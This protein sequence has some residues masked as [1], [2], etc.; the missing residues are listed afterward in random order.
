MSS[1]YAQW[2]YDDLRS[3]Q[4]DDGDDEDDDIDHDIDPANQED[5]DAIDEDIA[6]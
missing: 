3:W 2:D 1:Y 4:G 5:E 6:Q